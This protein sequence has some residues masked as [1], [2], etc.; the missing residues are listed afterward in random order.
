MALRINCAACV[1]PTG[2][3]RHGLI[4]L[5]SEAAFHLAFLSQSSLVMLSVVTFSTHAV[6][7]YTHIIYVLVAF[8]LCAYTSTP[9]L[10]LPRLCDDIFDAFFRSVGS[11]VLVLLGHARSLPIMDAVAQNEFRK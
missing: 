10:G 5:L 11:V 4:L 9:Q 2:F 6:H 3:A 7:V 8:P 1:N